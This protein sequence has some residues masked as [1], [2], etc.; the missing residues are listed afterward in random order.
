MFDPKDISKTIYRVYMT[1]MDLPLSDFEDLQDLKKYL[2]SVR[3]N[4]PQGEFIVYRM[5][6]NI[7]YD[8]MKY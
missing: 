5:S 1:P 2:E 6:T 3:Q 4:F 8:K 7:T